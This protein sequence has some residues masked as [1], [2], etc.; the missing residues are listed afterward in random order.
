ME[1]VSLYEKI[2]AGGVSLVAMFVIWMCKR[3]VSGWDKRIEALEENSVSNRTLESFKSQQQ[4]QHEANTG[5]FTNIEQR[6][7]RIEDGLGAVH[8]RIDDLFR[9]LIG[10]RK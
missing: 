8:K 1:Q 4:T 7:V 10:E 2:S 3:M 6:G 5:R 9:L